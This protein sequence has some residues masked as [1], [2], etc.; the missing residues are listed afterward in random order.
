MARCWVH[1]RTR[2][3][4]RRGRNGTRTSFRWPS[5]FGPAALR[6]LIPTT[7]GFAHWTRA[8]STLSRRVLPE[9]GRL[10]EGGISTSISGWRRNGSEHELAESLAGAFRGA[11]RRRTLPLFGRTAI[12]MSGGLD[13]LG[14]RLGRAA[15]G[16]PLAGSRCMTKT[17]WRFRSRSP[18]VTRWRSIGYPCGGSSSIT[19][20]RRSREPGSPG[21]GLFREQSLPGGSDPTS[22]RR[23]RQPPNRMLL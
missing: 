13:S 23:S 7:V 11:V 19:V 8:P 20:T 3:H 4:W 10:D 15:G 9:P 12:G 18:S 17:T 22:G 16:E 5:S 14:H 2:W 1:I 21:H 6:T